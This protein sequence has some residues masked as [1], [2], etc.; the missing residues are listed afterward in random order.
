[1][2]GGF[3]F[4]SLNRFHVINIQSNL[5]YNIYME[6]NCKEYNMS[7]NKKG[8]ENWPIIEQKGFFRFVILKVIFSSFIV[9]IGY[10]LGSAYYKNDFSF[11]F[12]NNKIIYIIT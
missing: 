8:I 1:M 7:I 4:D 12:F 3:Q 10:T 11:S 9:T 5:W 6:F 2:V